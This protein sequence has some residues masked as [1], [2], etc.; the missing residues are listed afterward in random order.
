M[1]EIKVE[2]VHPEIL[3]RAGQRGGDELPGVRM[4]PQLRGDPEVAALHAILAERISQRMT[5][6]DLVAV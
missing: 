2:I 6:L 1:H 5:D 4:S 3:E